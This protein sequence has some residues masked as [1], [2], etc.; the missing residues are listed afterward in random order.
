MTLQIGDLI[1]VR[2]NGPIDRLVEWAENGRYSHIGIYAGGDLIL[3]AQGM[4]KVGYAH[5]GAYTGEYD[6]GHVFGATDSQRQAALAS[7]TKRIGRRYAWR[8]IVLLALKLLF[9][10]DRPYKEEAALICST[11]A[12]DVWRDAGI[13]LTNADK[14]TPQQIAD[15]PVIVI[16]KP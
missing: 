14:P 2:G 12:L 9:H 3:E 6:V 7:A 4:R 16:Q 1:L 13:N 15:S 11:Y 10:L 8:L 5:L